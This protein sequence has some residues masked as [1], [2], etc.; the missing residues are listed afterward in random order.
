MPSAPQRVVRM[1]V[2]QTTEA[3]CANHA[4][5]ADAGSGILGYIFGDTVQC[6]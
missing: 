2:C 1:A 5:V 4:K 3:A 6:K